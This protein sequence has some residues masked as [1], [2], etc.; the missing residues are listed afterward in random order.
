MLQ[1]RQKSARERRFLPTQREQTAFRNVLKNTDALR[2]GGS[3]THLF[4]SLTH[5]L[6]QNPSKM[7]ERL[8]QS[9]EFLHSSFHGS[10]MRQ[11]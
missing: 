9:S 4:A 11:F 10:F 2:G 8:K 7:A 1:Y 5:I 3:L 6:A